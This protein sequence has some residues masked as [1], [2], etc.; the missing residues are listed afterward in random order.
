MSE[1]SVTRMSANPDRLDGVMQDFQVAANG[2]MISGRSLGEGPP[3]LLCHG[4]PET[5][6]SWHGVMVRLAGAGF[7]AIAPDMRG[8]GGSSAPREI[9]AYSQL[10]LVGDM[11]GLLDA[12]AVPA[13]AIVGHDWGAQVAWNAALM[14]PDRFKAVAGLSVPY[15]PRTTRNLLDVM[16]SSGRDRFYMLHFQEPGR[17][18]AELEA[19]A[20]RSLLAVY[21]GLSGAPS[22]GGTFDGIVGQH[23]FVESLRPPARPPS[24]LAPDLLDG[25]VAAFSRSGFRGGLNWYRNMDRDWQLLAPFDGAPISQPSLFIGG[26]ADMVVAWN[27]RTIEALP[28]H[29]VDLRGIHLLDGVGHWLQQEAPERT[30]DLLV[31]FLRESG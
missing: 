5:S 29:L 20:R 7:R 21:D 15:A 18:E 24:W 16:R 2:I 31:H 11:V 25:E 4:F 9:E 10:A 13:A 22:S 26:T 8:Y 19:D 17:A 27:A 6:L 12:L 14:R 23:G 1:T 30:A 28:R 3:V